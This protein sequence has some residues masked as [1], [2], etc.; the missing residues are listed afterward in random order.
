MEVYDKW[1]KENGYSYLS[2]GLIHNVYE[3]N[4]F[5]YKIVKSNIISSN[6]DNH[7]DKEVRCLDYLYNMGFNVVKIEKV[8]P[9]GQLIKDFCV[10]TEKKIKGICYN[11]ENIPLKCIESILDFIK[12]VEKITLSK[13][14]LIFDDD[15]LCDENWY[16]Y[17]YSQLEIAKLVIKKYFKEDKKMM[18][19]IDEINKE[20]L[21]NV[22]SH[23]LV[24]DPNPE[25]FIFDKENMVA[26]DID[27]PIGGDPL[28]QTASFYW[29]K[30]QWKDT[31]LKSNYYN[32]ENYPIMLVYCLVFGLTTFDFLEK[33]SIKIEQWN[34]ERIKR[35]MEEIE[36]EKNNR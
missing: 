28:W 2:S 4:G 21:Y 14:G 19:I 20:Y 3:K 29:Y 36:N 15:K 18:S 8:Y 6:T 24:M 13:Y 34:F 5:I 25:N 35:L 26:I 27:H 23:F 11:E 12:K 9:K 30:E 31:M 33:S 16:K 17:Y 1:L 32:Y 22:K 7:F 10:L